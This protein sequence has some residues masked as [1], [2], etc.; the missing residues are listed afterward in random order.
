MLRTKRWLTAVW[1]APYVRPYVEG[2][3]SQVSSSEPTTIG[4]DVT[5]RC[6]YHNVPAQDYYFDFSCRRCFEACGRVYV[7]RRCIEQGV[8]CSRCGGLVSEFRRDE[9]TQSDH[10]HTARRVEEQQAA[11]AELEDQP[12]TIE[13]RLAEVELTLYRFSETHEPM[14]EPP[15]V[16]PAATPAGERRLLHPLFRTHLEGDWICYEFH[17]EDE[18]Q[19]KVKSS[20]PRGC[21]DLKQHNQEVLWKDLPRSEA[22]RQEASFILVQDEAWLSSGWL[23]GL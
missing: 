10:A 18:P 12:V 8:R 17:P 23:L 13:E 2:P 22:L 15:A 4:N 14:P 11:N 20:V 9:G 21:R 7:C 16:V 19:F 6:C 1:H 3:M 5:V